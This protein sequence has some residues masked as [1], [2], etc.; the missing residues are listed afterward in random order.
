VPSNEGILRGNRT[1]HRYRASAGDYGFPQ[2]EAVALN[3]PDV[4]HSF[5]FPDL[6]HKADDR[7]ATLV[8]GNAREGRGRNAAAAYDGEL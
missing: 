3:E 1:I 5:V 6:F 7:R 2:A 4:P 8:A